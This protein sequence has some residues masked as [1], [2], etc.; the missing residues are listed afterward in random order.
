MRQSQSNGLNNTRGLA[1]VFDGMKAGDTAASSAIT[2][3][4]SSAHVMTWNLAMIDKSRR[5][6]D[7]KIN[8]A[9]FVY[10]K[11]ADMLP[12]NRQSIPEL[13]RPLRRNEC[14]LVWI[15]NVS[16]VQLWCVVVS[17]SVSGARWE[18]TSTPCVNQPSQ[19]LYHASFYLIRLCLVNHCYKLLFRCAKPSTRPN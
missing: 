17:V 16:S 1:V 9:P 13:A 15:V 5:R 7:N 12:S 6:F 18:F 14:G 4:R 19:S 3:R 11:F 2:A 8:V 10:W